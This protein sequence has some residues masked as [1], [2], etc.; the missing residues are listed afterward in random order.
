MP[1]S[2]FFDEREWTTDASP[3]PTERDFN[4]LSDTTD[5]KCAW[6]NF[7]RLSRVKAYERF[8]EHPL[9]FQEDFMFMGGVAFAYYY[10]VIEAICTTR[11]KNQRTKM[12]IGRL[13]FWPKPSRI[14]SP[15]RDCRT[16][17]IWGLASLHWP[18]M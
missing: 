17:G 15:L 1:A 10:P 9:N 18:N 6:E 4:P 7:G 16:S 11:V 3:L 14:N 2:K 5:A 12:T 8:L 13:G